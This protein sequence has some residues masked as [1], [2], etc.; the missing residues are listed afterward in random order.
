ML[1]ALMDADAPVAVGCV[2]GNKRC[3][4]VPTRLGFRTNLSSG[5]TNGGAD[6]EYSAAM[7]AGMARASPSWLLG[8][9]TLSTTWGD[10]GA[11]AG[12]AG[13][14]DG[15]AMRGFS[16]S[17]GEKPRRGAGTSEFCKVTALG[18]LLAAPYDSGTSTD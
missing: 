18:W 11:A 4:G 14:A 2:A 15:A 12:A 6:G 10:G 16:D 13:P 3:E 7:G 5:R 1:M 17:T 8:R 9:G